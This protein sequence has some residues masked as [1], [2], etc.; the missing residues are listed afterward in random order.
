[1]PYEEF[2]KGLQWSISLALR[3]HGARHPSRRTRGLDEASA[4][5]LASETIEQLR[6]SG[7]VLGHR[8][9]PVATWVNGRSDITVAPREELPPPS[10]GRTDADKE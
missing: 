8:E 1:M 9:H 4:S 6:L 2:M 3:G 10:T 7:Y 5:F